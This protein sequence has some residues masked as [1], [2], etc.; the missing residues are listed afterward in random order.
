[1]KETQKQKHHRDQMNK[2]WI[3]KG[4]KH[5]KRNKG[6][7]LKRWIHKNEILKLKIANK[8]RPASKLTTTRE[9]SKL[10]KKRVQNSSLRLIYRM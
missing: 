6:Q 8:E 4:L 7:I 2:N 5:L 9:R 1:M 3:N 10:P